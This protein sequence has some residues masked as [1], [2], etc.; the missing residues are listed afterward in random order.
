MKRLLIASIVLAM[1]APAL[2][3][4]QTRTTQPQ[5]RTSDPDL[6]NYRKP[7][8]R[9]RLEK[10][11]AGRWWSAERYQAGDAQRRRDAH[12]CTSP[13][14]ERGKSPGM[15]PCSKGP[16]RDLRPF[17]K[18]P[19]QQVAPLAADQN[20]TPPHQVN[21]D[22][23]P[24]T[25]QRPTSAVGRLWA[26]T[27]WSRLSVGRAF[28]PG[29]PATRRSDLVAPCAAPSTPWPNASTNPAREEQFLVTS[30]VASASCREAPHGCGRSL[31][32][33]QAAIRLRR[34]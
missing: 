30:A 3:Q 32:R 12:A 19:H 8:R 18:P 2:A 22:C 17:G 25:M 1:A 31:R 33:R 9:P 11:N 4:S 26:T 23:A 10:M 34:G 14:G 21:S 29:L 5:T 15:S 28:L 27:G 16:S 20:C 24:F 6:Y 13:I 7:K